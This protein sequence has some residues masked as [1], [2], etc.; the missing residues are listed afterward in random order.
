MMAVDLYGQEF[1]PDN[2]ITALKDRLQKY[3][4]DTEYLDNREAMNHY[5]ELKTWC[6]LGGYTSEDLNFVKKSF[7][8]Q[9]NND[10]RK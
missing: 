6:F 7:K 2:R 4:T 3:Y 1:T 9:F 5:K 10:E 8:F